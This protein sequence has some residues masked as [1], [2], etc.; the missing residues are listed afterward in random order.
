VSTRCSWKIELKATDDNSIEVKNLRCCLVDHQVLEVNIFLLDI[1]EI[2]MFSRYVRLVLYLTTSLH[3]QVWCR[4]SNYNW[5]FLCAIP[6]FWEKMKC[7]H[8]RFWFCQILYVSCLY[9]IR[10]LFVTDIFHPYSS[11]FHV[12][13]CKKKNI[14]LITIISYSKNLSVLFS[15]FFWSWTLF[16][17]FLIFIDQFRK[18]NFLFLSL[19][20]GIL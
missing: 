9:F 17:M 20:T 5:L 10:E 11:S 15:Y 3:W 14:T 2:P 12:E 13:F 1:Y 7:T 16:L 8:F 4:V 19:T 18:K 6:Y